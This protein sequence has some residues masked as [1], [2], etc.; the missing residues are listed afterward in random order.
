MS[1]STATGV[2][3]AGHPEACAD[4]GR[5]A[6]APAESM[7]RDGSGIT[8][9]AAPEIVLIVARAQNGVIGRDNSLPWHLPDDLRRFKALTLGK[10][11]LMGRKTHQAIGRP[12][13]GRL[14]IVLTR[15]AAWTASGVSVVLSLD[16]ALTA[17]GPAPEIMVIGGA[18][19]YRQLLPRANRIELTEVAADIEGDT[20]LEPFPDAEWQETARESHAPDERHAWPFSFVTL[21]RRA[22]RTG[23]VGPDP[24]L[25]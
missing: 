3:V 7:T 2:D 5:T 13:P 23:S 4:G 14:N 21:R 12:L 18:E 11:V 19:L 24:P 22:A 25:R 1:K 17:A 10:P 6:Q 9:G 15:D 20:R 8:A 16:E